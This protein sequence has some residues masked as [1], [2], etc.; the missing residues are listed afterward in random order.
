MLGFTLFV[1]ILYL[2]LCCYF[3]LCPCLFIYFSYSI[4]LYLLFSVILVAIVHGF[5]LFVLFFFV[6]TD[7]LVY[8]SNS[9]QFYLFFSDV[10]VAVVHCFNL[11]V[12]FLFIFINSHSLAI[13]YLF[14]FLKSQ[15]TCTRINSF[16]PFV[17]LKSLFFFSLSLSTVFFIYSSYS[18]LFYLFLSDVLVAKVLGFTLFGLIFFI[19]VYLSHRLS[20][21]YIFIFPSLY[22]D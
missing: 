10:I 22:N 4:L 15:A 16:R 17:F 5:T 11:F 6:I 13:L 8:F 12:L 2:F 9:I 18:I 14:F 21:S 3:P 19:F 1:F 7:L 20:P